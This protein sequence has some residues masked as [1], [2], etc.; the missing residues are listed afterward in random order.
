M[1][2]VSPQTAVEIIVPFFM[3]FY[4]PKQVSFLR[5]NVFVIPCISVHFPILSNP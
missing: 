2:V 1:N 4:I 3:F 5:L